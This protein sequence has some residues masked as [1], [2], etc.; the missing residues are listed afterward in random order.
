MKEIRSLPSEGKLEKK[1]TLE[2]V[3]SERDNVWRMNRCGQVKRDRRK[4]NRIEK[5]EYIDPQ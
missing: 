1:N 3:W 4:E 5:K 2:E